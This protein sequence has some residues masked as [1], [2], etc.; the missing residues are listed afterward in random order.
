[1]NDVCVRSFDDDDDDDV[2]V[3]MRVSGEVSRLKS[4]LMSLWK[5]RTHII[6]IH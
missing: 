2:S 4:R 3:Y 6:N 1:M 5:F